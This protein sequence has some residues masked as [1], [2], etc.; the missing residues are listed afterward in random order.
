MGLFFF[1]LPAWRINSCCWEGILFPFSVI[2]FMRTKHLIAW[3]YPGGKLVPITATSAAS[4]VTILRTNE[5]MR[6]E[7][8]KGERIVSGEERRQIS[9]LFSWAASSTMEAL[10]EAYSLK[11]GDQRSGAA[12]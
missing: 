2:L 10:S 3:R 1:S 11:G 6:G 12:S 7:K 4:A 8:F 9:E 5:R